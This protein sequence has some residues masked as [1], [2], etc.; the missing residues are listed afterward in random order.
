MNRSHILFAVLLAG[1]G[2][3][4]YGP[5]AGYTDEPVSDLS[6]YEARL[7]EL[8]NRLH[9]TSLFGPD[10]QILDSDITASDCAVAA[11]LRDRI[12]DLS[13]RICDIAAREPSAAD[14][15]LKCQR[16]RNACAEAK[17]SVQRGCG[18]P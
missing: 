12:C 11:D 5:S 14:V 13:E 7:D 8:N 15:A 3:A 1:C 6:G 9:A 18:G 17:A 4:S 2:P 16:A 10:A